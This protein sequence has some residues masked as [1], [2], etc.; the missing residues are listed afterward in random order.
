M[1]VA[2]GRK[3][4]LFFFKPMVGSM[5][6]FLNLYFRSNF[7]MHMIFI[8]VT[9]KRI[10][11]RGML[12]QWEIWYIYDLYAPVFFHSTWK[13]AF[14]QGHIILPFDNN[15]KGW[16][17]QQKNGRI[18]KG[19]STLGEFSY[20]GIILSLSSETILTGFQND[21]IDQ[22]HR[23]FGIILWLE[24]LWNK[25]R[26]MKIE[27]MAK[28]KD[29]SRAEMFPCESCTLDIRGCVLCILHQVL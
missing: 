21:H 6:D 28:K 8:T 3:N 9:K 19:K 12:R 26:S 17:P 25:S 7:T 23:H 11:D 5:L 16:I 10:L 22:I 13:L 2:S 15:L 24:Y 20:K 1:Y 18:K 14:R 27:T 4:V 29:H